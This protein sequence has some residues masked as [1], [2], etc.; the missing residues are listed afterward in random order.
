[1]ILP[2]K[3]QVIL[4][5]KIYETI[6]R[7]YI[8]RN[9]AITIHLKMPS[10]TPFWPCGVHSVCL[11]REVFDHWKLIKKKE[12]ENERKNGQSVRNTLSKYIDDFN[13]HTW[14]QIAFTPHF[15]YMNLNCCSQWPRAQHARAH[16]PH[17]PSVNY[18]AMQSTLLLI[19]WRLSIETKTF[20]RFT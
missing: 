2:C 5:W 18:S 15:S 1:M 4:V 9:T 7:D 16:N 6:S 14:V 17:F 11:S 13:R 12:N 8:P 20:S 10:I 3:G 19:K